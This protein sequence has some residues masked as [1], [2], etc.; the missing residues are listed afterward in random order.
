MQ[1]GGK[2]TYDAWALPLLALLFVAVVMASNSL[3]RNIRWD[4][5]E[6]QLY[7]M[8]QGTRNIL[9]GLEEPINL[10]F[11]F[12]SD[13][14]RDIPAVRNYANRV[15]ELL[16]EFS[17]NSDGK[18]HLRVIDPV[19]FSEEEEMAAEFGLTPV[20]IG[21]SGENIYLGLAGTNMVDDASTIAFFHPDKENFLEYDLAKLVYSLDHPER[22]VIGVLSGLPM[23]RDFDPVTQQIRQAWVIAD[24]AE[25]LFQ[26]RTLPAN[27]EQVD[28]DVD[29]LML[30]HPRKL[31]EQTL[32]AIDQFVMRGGRALI[33][34]DPFAESEAAAMDQGNLM[35][36]RAG[37]QSSN[38]GPLFSAWGIR[39]DPGQVIADEQLAL[40]VTMGPGRPSVRHLAFLGFGPG[41]FNRDDIITAKLDL[42]NMAT[43][44][45]FELE[46]HS[47]LTMTPLL[48]TSPRAMPVTAD[49]FAYMPDPAALRNGFE[50]TGQ[51]YTV[52]ARLSGPL[53]SAFPNGSPATDGEDAG[54]LNTSVTDAT[55]ILFADTDLLTDRFWVQV[56][57]FLDQ[58][59]ATAFANNGDLL[60]NA[61]D[62][63]SGSSDLI[64]IRGRAG[65]TRPFSRVEALRR[66]A[67]ASLQAKEQELERQLKTTEES[68]ARLQSQRLDQNAVLLSDEQSV[69]LQKFLGE[70][71]RIQKELR[72]VRLE[73]DR[74]IDRLGSSL[75]FI[76]IG[77]IPLALTLALIL[78]IAIAGKR[79]EARKP[80]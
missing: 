4:L 68:L 3:F 64:S 61:L 34:V 51:V 32:Y 47:T 43:V 46:S 22:P 1:T 67:E 73:L 13:A 53:E 54:H 52:A 11:F 60:V 48:Q 75:K 65:Y 19:P 38:L 10:Y 78:W 26:L 18:I 23:Q 16:E 49:R 59:L 17:A 77:L 37:S 15:R 12:S 7:T 42:V 71:V 29:L 28:E 56:Q 76:N 50:P 57:T 44:G 58:R 14:S 39:Y 79:R 36:A 70:K 6:N 63:L 41:Q 72:Q 31:S 9:G 21:T 80:I 5:T 66:E 8:S 35:A 20:P 69:E 30:V 2:K 62:N 45:V 25:Q 40:S 24:Q 55:I 74:E 33:F 27:L